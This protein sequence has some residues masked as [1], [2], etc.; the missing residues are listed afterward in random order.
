MKDPKRYPNAADM[1]RVSLLLSG[2][3]T[4]SNMDPLVTEYQARVD[5]H[6]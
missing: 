5:Y 2:K 6:C 4:V 1:V 3:C